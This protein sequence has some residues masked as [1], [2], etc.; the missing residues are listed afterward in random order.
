[1]EAFNQ[2]REGIFVKHKLCKIL[3]EINFYVSSKA[4]SDAGLVVLRDN[5]QIA[6][7]DSN[8]VAGDKCYI[9]C[10]MHSS[11]DQQTLVVDVYN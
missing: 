6:A 3:Y 2:I 8:H 11:V 4:L 1:M 5:L 9:L 7:W 10:Y